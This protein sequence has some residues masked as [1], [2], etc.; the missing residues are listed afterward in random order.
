MCNMSEPVMWRKTLTLS[1]RIWEQEP[2]KCGYPDVNF[3]FVKKRRTNRSNWEHTSVDGSDWHKDARSSNILSSHNM[4]TPIFATPIKYT[5]HHIQLMNW[6]V[7][8]LM[9]A[10][11]LRCHTSIF[12]LEQGRQLKGNKQNN[13][14]NNNPLDAAPTEENRKRGQKRSQFCV[15]RYLDTLVLKGFKS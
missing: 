1:S 14:N 2:K 15:E 11:L 10:S 4:K 3:R 8:S 6:N 9:H 13:N 12:L 7:A 5:W